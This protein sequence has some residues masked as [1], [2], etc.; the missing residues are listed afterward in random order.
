[1]GLTGKHK[2]RDLWRQKDL[3]EFEGAITGTAPRHGVLL[4]RVW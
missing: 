1:L 2:A 4:V 3:G